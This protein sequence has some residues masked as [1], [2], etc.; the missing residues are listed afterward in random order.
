MPG[1]EPGTL[2]QQRG[3]LT[4]RPLYQN[5]N[6]RNVRNRE[7]NDIYTYRCFPGNSFNHLSAIL[8]PQCYTYTP[9][10]YKHRNFCAVLTLVE[11]LFSFILGC[12]KIT[13]FDFSEHLQHTA[14]LTSLLCEINYKNTRTTRHSCL[15]RLLSQTNSVAL[16]PQANYTDWVTAT[17]QLLWIE[18]CRVVSVADPLRSLISVF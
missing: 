6:W 9:V 7:G 12:V 4:T 8:M 14:K 3:S 17:C 1:I 10:D 18:G 5:S 11:N 2:G 15:W 16:S 13:N